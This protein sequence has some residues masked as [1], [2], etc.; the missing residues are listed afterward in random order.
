LQRLRANF[1]V[2]FGLFYMRS[3]TVENKIFVKVEMENKLKMTKKK[4]DINSQS[5]ESCC[6]HFVQ[7]ERIKCQTDLKDLKKSY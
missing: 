5:G 3:K 7:I 2:S 4:L 1:L 6:I